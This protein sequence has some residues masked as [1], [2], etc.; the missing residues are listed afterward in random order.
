MAPDVEICKIC[1]DNFIVN[2]KIVKCGSCKTKY[3][4]GCSSIK[5]SWLKIISECDNLFWLC[6]FCKSTLTE[7]RMKIVILQKEI[8][9]LKREKSLTEKLLTEMEYM[10]EVHK[11]ILKARPLSSDYNITTNKSPVTA[12]TSSA[13]SSYSAAC[14]QSVPNRKESPVLHIKSSLETSTSKDVLADIKKSINP[15]RLNICIDN[16]RE[17]KH[18]V[19]VHC[20]SESSREAL[21]SKLT[22]IFGSKYEITIANK[23]NPRLLIKNVNLDDLISHEEIIESISTLNDLEDWTSEIKI[24][25]KLKHYQSMNLVI[26]VT[27]SL[28]KIIV[29]RGF[30]FIGWKK[31][32]VS[33]HLQIRKCSNCCGLGH[34]NKECKLERIC[35]KCAE[36]HDEKSC[37]ATDFQCIR[38]VNYNKN[39]KKKLPTSHAA[40]DKECPMLKNYI[41]NLSSNINYG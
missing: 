40:Y 28:R 21:K 7:S 33:D 26:E 25:T 30:L 4:T 36:K 22:D 27:P 13:P 16:I 8:E 24:V 1:N 2:S 10:N 17:S 5:D 14:K 6:D 9:C 35:P 29:Q 41:S 34:L 38:C 37:K 23:L 39:K 11:S 31:C 32:P 20:D 3:H 15:A 12:L 18:G 19:A